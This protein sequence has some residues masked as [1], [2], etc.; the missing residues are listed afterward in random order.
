MAGSSALNTNTV[1][2][3]VTTSVFIGGE[4]L[5][6]EH[7]VLD[8]LVEKE[9]NRIPSARIVLLDGDP[10]QRDF[11]LSDTDMFMPGNEVEIRA[12]YHSDEETIFE[13]VV[14][15]HAVRIR[16]DHSYLTVVCKDVS[17]KL[18]IGRKNKCFYDKT[19][20]E[21][22]GEIVDTYRIENEI[23]STD[24]R[25]KEMVQFSATD[26]DFCVVRAQAN[27]KVCIVDDGKI[28][29][30]TPDP[31][32]PAVV[33]AEFG[34]TILD[35]DAEMD[36]R[37]QAGSI[38]ASGWN[39]AEQ[40][41]EEVEAEMP[42]LLLNGN[43]DFKELSKALGEV[44]VEIRNGGNMPSDELQ[45]WADAR[46]FFGRMSKTRGRVKVR[47][48]AEI[49]PGTVLDIEGVGERF[50][51]KVFVSGARH[52][53]VN[54]LWTVDAQFGIDP[55]WFAEKADVSDLPA[56]G[57]LAAVHGLQT[58][59]VTSLEDPGNAGHIK[60]TIPAYEGGE[61][62]LWARVA[63]LDAGENRGS[64]FMPEVDDEV[65]LG[66]VN[67]DPRMP[68]VLGMLNSSAKP[69]PLQSSDDNNEK[70]FVTRSGMKLLFDDEKKSITIVTP[71]GKKIFA[72]DD[73]GVIT[74][75]DENSNEVTLNSSGI[76][77]KSSGN[78][79]IK[80]G[81]DVEIEG[82]NVNVKAKMELKA[83]SDMTVQLSATA[84]TEIKGAIVKIN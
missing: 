35:F 49:K 75:E 55:K 83:E 34:S 1:T 71:G 10:A 47:G 48:N 84:T 30:K 52:Q 69:P 81:G 66:F 68:V 73:S 18:T 63:T 46:A 13:G 29:V 70:G 41:V 9:I 24:V 32:G 19:D 38:K 45:Q 15:K 56:S 39:D 82:N 21:I 57:L 43:V 3:L 11:A 76:K 42:D 17:V 51:G 67:D 40:A 59:V 5:S 7:Q 79:S 14:V 25:H 62:E 26:W 22:I 74:L 37:G 31:T 28:S 44:T 2:D 65:I 16:P 4:E 50:N 27:G 53:I 64:F 54:G 12:G 77:L 23:E 8:I 33:S 58:G 6:A 78:I 61:Q 36:A 20:S 60:V 80:A 72:D